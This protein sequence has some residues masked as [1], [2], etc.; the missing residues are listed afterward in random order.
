MPSR[1]KTHVLSVSLVIIVSAFFA[2]ALLVWFIDAVSLI[3]YAPGSRYVLEPGWLLIT[4]LYLAF[5][6][7]PLVAVV[8]FL[9]RMS[10]KHLTASRAA[11]R[12]FVISVLVLGI[13]SGLYTLYVTRGVTWALI[14][15]AIVGAW[16][17]IFAAAITTW[18]FTRTAQSSQAR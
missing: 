16:Y 12:A 11:V 2:T 15:A 18:H 1:T 10:T 13:P 4:T 8:V 7:G 14:A 6:W 9:V 3:V 5:V 17:G